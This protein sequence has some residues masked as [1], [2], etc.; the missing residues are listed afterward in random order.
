MA[1]G[2]AAALMVVTVGAGVISLITDI[3]LVMSGVAK[4]T[5]NGDRSVL[6]RVL[7]TLLARLRFEVDLRLYSEIFTSLVNR[8]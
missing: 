1:L 4:P 2:V 6:L 3:C 5:R 8:F 7:G